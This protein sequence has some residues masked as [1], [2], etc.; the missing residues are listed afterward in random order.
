MTRRQWLKFLAWLTL[1][2]LA[3][4]ALYA[5]VSWLARDLWLEP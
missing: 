1:P 3:I 2:A 4:L 5:L